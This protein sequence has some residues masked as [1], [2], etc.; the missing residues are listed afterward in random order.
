MFECVRK[1]SK[2]IDRIKVSPVFTQPHPEKLI[3][4]TAEFVKE[5]RISPIYVDKYFNLLDGYC[6]YLIAT[7]LGY[8]KVK[9]MQFRKREKPGINNPQNNEDREEKT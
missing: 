5:G 3:K 2:N 9:I 7:T 8:K 1:K 4:K 6:S